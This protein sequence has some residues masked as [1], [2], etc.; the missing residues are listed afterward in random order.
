MIV[1]SGLMAGVFEKYKDDKSNIVFASGVSNSME[2]NHSEYKREF[3]LLSQYVKKNCKLIYFSTIS[4]FDPSLQNSP[5]IIHKKNIEK[6][7]TKNFCSYI[8]FR[9]PIIISNSKNPNTFFNNFVNKL[10]KN[11]DLKIN[12]MAHRYIF[13]ADDLLKTLPLWIDV[14]SNL[15]INIAY[16]N[17]DSVYNI[18]KQMKDLTNSNSNIINVPSETHSNYIVDNYVF[19]SKYPTPYNYNT[20]TLNKYLNGKT[21]K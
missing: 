1:G 4:I 17:R 8:I 12:E 14:C 2:K 18:V 21:N 15:S 6:F 13:D 19:E 16:N 5:Y 3:D 9:L 7:I 20:T 11:E 10:K